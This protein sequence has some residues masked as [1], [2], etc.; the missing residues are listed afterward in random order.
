M[1]HV[2]GWMAANYHD[3]RNHYCKLTPSSVPRIMSIFIE[4]YFLKDMVL[5][6]ARE[7]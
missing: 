4:L 6:V 2:L 3:H 5:Q 7:D 1:G